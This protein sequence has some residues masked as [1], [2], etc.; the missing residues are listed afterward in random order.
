VDNLKLSAS[1]GLIKEILL[2]GSM[3]DENQITKPIILIVEDHDAVRTLVRDWL[4]RT[5]T[6]CRFL[7][8]KSGEEA[9]ALASA[10][11]PDIVTMDIGL[12][13]MNGIETT[14]HI[15]AAV[16]QAQV[17]ILTVH[18]AAD[19]MADAD[20]ARASAYV[21]KSE[22]G[23]K[24]IPEVARLLSRLTGRK[25]SQGSSNLSKKKWGKDE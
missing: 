12:P 19:F 18:D 2:M 6:E 23:S 11:P 3:Q 20:A 10:Q 21:P 17:V 16:P 22:V 1:D 15:K 4:S 5:F 7:E 13:R 24:L 14:R 8:A 9:I 25:W